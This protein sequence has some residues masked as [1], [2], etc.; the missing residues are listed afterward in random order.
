MVLK[1]ICHF[2]LRPRIY[3]LFQPVVMSAIGLDFSFTVI[4]SKLLHIHSRL[5]PRYPNTCIFSWQILL[6]RR[7]IEIEKVKK[8]KR[9]FIHPIG[10]GNRYV[11][12]HSY[13]GSDSNRVP[14]LTDVVNEPCHETSM[15]VSWPIGRPKCIM[16][17]YWVLAGSDAESMIGDRISKLDEGQTISAQADIETLNVDLF[18]P[19]PRHLPWSASHFNFPQMT[20]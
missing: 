2:G 6:H 19:V 1:Y 12:T 13:Y 8:P 14:T 16:A 4:Q 3:R 11:L 10:N 17:S 9:R 18:D 15:F 7:S 5:L 20:Y